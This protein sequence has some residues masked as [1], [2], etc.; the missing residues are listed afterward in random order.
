[1]LI[2]I[3]TS[4]EKLVQ[5]K[6]AMFVLSVVISMKVSLC[7]KIL[8]VLFVNIRQALLLNYKKTK[9]NLAIYKATVIK[10]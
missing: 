4:K 3:N 2:I 5:P 1:M 9:I 7:L 8:Y 6:K 10:S